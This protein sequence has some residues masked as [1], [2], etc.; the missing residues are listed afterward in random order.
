MLINNAG[1]GLAGSTEE[2]PLDKDEKMMILNVISVVELCKLFL[3][4]MYKQDKGKF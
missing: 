1:F 3:N 2:I 4:D